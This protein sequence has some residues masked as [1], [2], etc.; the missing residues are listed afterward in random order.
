MEG[1]KVHFPWFCIWLMLN[2]F[3]LS[4]KDFGPS[5]LHFF[6]K[7]NEKTSIF[8]KLRIVHIHARDYYNKNK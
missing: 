2:S 3:F 1:K 4:F 8:T 5:L 7:R 6:A